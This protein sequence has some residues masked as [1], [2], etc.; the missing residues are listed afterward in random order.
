MTLIWNTRPAGRLEAAG[1]SAGQPDWFCLPLLELM[2]YS[3]PV[4]PQGDWPDW[5]ISVS[6]LASRL[7]LAQLGAQPLARFKLFAVGKAS[8]EPWLQAGLDCAYPEQ[9]ASEALLAWADWQ[10]LAGL[11]VW[12]ARGDDGRE[13]LAQQL[14][15]RGAEVSYVELYQRICPVWTEAQ[16]AALRQSWSAIDG[17]WLSSAAALAHLSQLALPI[18][19]S[20]LYSKRLF[21]VSPRLTEIARQQGFRQI[22]TLPGPHLEQLLTA[23]RQL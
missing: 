17:I 13:L 7:M 21:L 12:I 16:Q 6:P 10:Q 22:Y 8:A 19:G 20:E 2:P 23:L 4:W 15:I 9:G 11:N 14:Q 5:L 3:Q 1:A 18:L